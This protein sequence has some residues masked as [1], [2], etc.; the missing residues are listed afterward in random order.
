MQA[1]ANGISRALVAG[2]IAGAGATVRAATLTDAERSQICAE[3]TE[4]YRQIF[5][6]APG[7]EPFVVVLMYRDNFCP[8]ALTVQQGTTLR[9]VNVD[10][11]TSHS[12]W[13][14]EAGRPESERTFPEEFVTMTIDLP[15]GE[16]PY[17]CGPH[18]EREGM[19]GRLTVTER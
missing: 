14:K 15:P 18:W 19:A 11:R 8:A 7:E 13:F 5:G 12:V 16:Y 9:W 2:L 17:L 3:A 6:K 1:L 10:R 4:R